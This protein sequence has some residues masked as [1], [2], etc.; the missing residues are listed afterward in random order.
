M[1][2]SVTISQPVSA[3]HIIHYARF[4]HN[5][6]GSTCK[7]DKEV[8]AQSLA[9]KIL[10]PRHAVQLRPR[11]FQRKLNLVGKGGFLLDYYSILHLFSGDFFC[12]LVF[13]S[14]GNTIHRTT[15]IGLD[16]RKPHLPGGFELTQVWTHFEHRRQGIARDVLSAILSAAPECQFHWCVRFDNESSIKF[17]ER[18]GFYGVGLYKITRCLGVSF[19]RHF[20]PTKID[21]EDNHSIL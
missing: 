9:S 4:P 11:L 5:N 2:P 14:L 8:L 7:M 12:I 18:C 3:A 10:S 15:V 1:D 21:H 17:I 6:V 13:D 20:K 19:F 16:I